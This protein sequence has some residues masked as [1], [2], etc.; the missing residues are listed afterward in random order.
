MDFNSNLNNLFTNYQNQQNYKKQKFDVNGDGKINSKDQTALNKEK[1]ELLKNKNLLFDVNGDGQFTQADVDMFVK[2]DFDG[3]GETSALEE[4]FVKQYKNDLKNVFVKQKADFNLDD[5]QYYD[6][7]VASGIIE[8]KFYK[9]GKLGTGM[10]SGKYYVNGNLADGLVNKVLYQDGVRFTGVNESDGLYYRSGTLATATVK[11]GNTTT[12]YIKGVMQYSAT[13]NNGNDYPKVS[14]QNIQCKNGSKKVTIKLNVG[15]VAVINADGTTSITNKDGVEKI[16]NA[17]GQLVKTIDVPAIRQENLEKTTKSI[18]KYVTRITDIFLAYNPQDPFFD[19]TFDFTD[20]VAEYDD[21][22]RVTKLESKY[23]SGPVISMTYDENNNITVNSESNE[24]C[25]TFTLD[26]EGKLTSFAQD[27]SNSSYNYEYDS[28]GKLVKAVEQ[29][30]NYVHTY[31][32]EYDDKGNMIKDGT[33]GKYENTYDSNGK[34]MSVKCGADEIHYDANGNIIKKVEHGRTLNYE[35]DANG[36]FVKATDENGNE[37]N[38]SG[39]VVKGENGRVPS[40]QVEVKIAENGQ[41]IISYKKTNEDGTTIE[42]ISD[43]N[44][45]D[46]SQTITLS[47]G[48]TVETIFDSKDSRM[49]GSAGSN[50]SSFSS[51]NGKGNMFPRVGMGILSQTV[52]NPDGSVAYTLENPSASAISS[53]LRCDAESCTSSIMNLTFTNGEHVLV[54]EDGSLTVT[55]TDGSQET[56]IKDKKTKSYMLQ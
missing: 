26:S 50:G 2:G 16:Y 32:F 51:L 6:G 9:S 42:Y 19:G 21:Q 1:T 49:G 54:N 30:G 28:A 15:D 38:Q 48:T 41:K 33:G 5:K 44:G 18:E 13:D 52:K 53:L 35:Y 56:Y 20:Y 36:T 40:S 39:C 7:K 8:G 47:D 43:I 27:G 25:R 11:D 34:L 55:K 17:K 10:Y 45:F 14:G 23:G 31:T 46:I 4:K 12:K 29:Q 24:R 37:F 22:N 3:D